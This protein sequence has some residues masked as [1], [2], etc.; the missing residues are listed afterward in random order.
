MGVALSELGRQRRQGG[1]ARPDPRRLYD[2]NPPSSSA[3]IPSRL[4]LEHFCRALSASAELEIVPYA[5][6]RY[7]RL[8]QRLRIGEVELGWLPPVVALEALRFGVTPLALPLRGPTPWFWTALFVRRDS[9]IDSLAGLVGA[10]AVWADRE[11]A[12]GY[13]VMRASLRSAGVDVD[14]CFASEGFAG[15]HDAVVHAVLAD[16]RSV[17]AT[18]VHLDANGQVERAGWGQAPVRVLRT[19][20]PIPSDVL[21]VSSG[22]APAARER[23]LAALSGSESNELREATNALFAARGFAAAERAHLAHLEMLGRYLVR[24]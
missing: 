8:L 16:P 14:R 12:S 2:S 1:R 13:L 17:G 15:A 10:N 18:Y 22:L 9:P 3:G 11:S 20:G 6:P 21:A 4:Q 7:D 19:A 23:I 5:A 24:A